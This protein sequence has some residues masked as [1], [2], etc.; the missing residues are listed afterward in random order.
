[1]IEGTI[2]VR[3]GWAFDMLAGWCGTAAAGAPRGGLLLGLLLAGMAGST[4]HCAPMCG[5]FVLGQ[6]SD[7]MAA[8]PAARMCELRRVGAGLLLPYHLGRWTTYA[9]LGAIAG[10]GGAAVGTLS[11]LGWVSGALLLLA[12]TLF[13]LHGLGRLLPAAR[14]VVPRLDRAPALWNRALVQTTHRINRTRWTGGYLLGVALGFLPCG[15]LYGALAAAAASTSPLVG[16]AAMLAFGLGTAPALIVVG[17]AGQ[18]AGR[19]WHRAVAI[20]A[21]IVMLA[22]ASL[23]ALLAVRELTGAA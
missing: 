22:N 23:L 18:A 16:A 13:L 6:V 15:F 11:W 10:A 17:V 7:R 3:M 8:I 4:M 2:S 21:P 20:A 14:F 12:A 19:K 9:G 1:M 5:G